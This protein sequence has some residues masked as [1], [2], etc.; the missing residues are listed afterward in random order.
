MKIVPISMEEILIYSFLIA[1]ALMAV[2]FLIMRL[3]HRTI[4]QE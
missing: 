2:I 4:I 3:T 1:L